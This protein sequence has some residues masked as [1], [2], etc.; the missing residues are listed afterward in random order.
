MRIRVATS[1]MHFVS[2]ETRTHFDLT[3]SDDRAWEV[4]KYLDSRGG[5]GLRKCLKSGIGH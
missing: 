1:T 4:G 2:L 3:D 5:S